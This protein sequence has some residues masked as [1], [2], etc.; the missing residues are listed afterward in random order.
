MN[1]D[2]SFRT[3][4]YRGTARD[5]D[6]FRL[7]YPPSLVDDLR[8]RAGLR[9]TGRLLDLA[10][11][12]GQIACALSAA[13]DQIVA[14]DQEPATIAFGR[15]K[16]QALGFTNIGWQVGT[17][18]EADVP[19][20][21][22]MVTIGNA[23][24][25]LRRQRVAERALSWLRPGGYA[26]LLWGGNPSEGTSDWQEVLRA[27]MVDWIGRAGDRLPA[28]W[29]EAMARDSHEQVLSRVGF[30]YEGSHDF[31]LR[32]VWTIDTLTGYL[33]S[34]SVLSRRALGD[35]APF[36]EEDLSA[37]MLRC[38]AN[39]KFEQDVRFSYQL[40]QRPD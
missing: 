28:D 24:H 17:A 10:C 40:A 32:H 31:S 3:D 19:G 8:W 30:S 21:F 26:A 33:Y 1:A 35:R 9:G 15:A 29:E 12:T 13:F 16:S 34:T 6:S 37:R 5:Y 18:E 39:G 20:P 4:L 23:F 27:V 11:G 22:D 7:S 36:F 2:P 14:L 38:H 25:R